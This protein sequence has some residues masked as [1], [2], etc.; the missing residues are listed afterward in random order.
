MFMWIVIFILPFLFI[1]GIIQALRGN[2]GWVL[3]IGFIACFPAMVIGEEHFGKLGW[4]PGVGGLIGIGIVAT[5][6][7]L[8]ILEHSSAIRTAEENAMKYQAQLNAEAIMEATN[9]RGY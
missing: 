4:T 9:R 7:I 2:T 3:M 5:L 6:C 1:N 8:R